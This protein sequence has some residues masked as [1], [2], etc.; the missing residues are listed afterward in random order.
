[1]FVW[2]FCTRLGLTLNRSCIET[3]VDTFVWTICGHLT[4]GLLLRLFQ[5]L[6]GLV[7]YGTC[8]QGGLSSRHFLSSLSIRLERFV[9]ILPFD[10]LM[11]GSAL[12]HEGFVLISKV[13]FWVDKAC[14]Q[15][16]LSN[17]LLARLNLGPSLHS[18]Q[19]L[20]YLSM[21]SSGHL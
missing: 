7:H 5:L 4:L 9:P 13:A 8:L 12:S 17:H 20:D 19:Q 10:E 16:Q 15:L 14:K 18:L 3:H 2:P 21:V 6:H 11:P 1:M